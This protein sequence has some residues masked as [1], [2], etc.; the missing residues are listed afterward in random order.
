MSKTYIIKNL[1]SKNYL[2]SS[3][4]IK[5]GITTGSLVLKIGHN[6][7]ASSSEQSTNQTVLGSYVFRSLFLLGA[8]MMMMMMMMMAKLSLGV[9]S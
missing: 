3:R 8:C 5:R 1:N 9:T 4:C 2:Q 7:M 6:Q